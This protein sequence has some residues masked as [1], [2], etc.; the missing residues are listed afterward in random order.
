MYFIIYDLEATCWQGKPITK[1]QEVIEIGAVKM[2]LYGE[3]IEAFSRFV[4]PVLNPVLSAYCQELTSI[5][6]IDINRA[7]TFNNVIEDF[8]DWIEVF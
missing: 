4:R 5:S 2:D 3:I 1:T 7:D 8:Q 6:Q